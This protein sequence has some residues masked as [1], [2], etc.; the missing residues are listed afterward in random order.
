MPTKKEVTSMTRLSIELIEDLEFGGSAARLPDFPA[1]GA[2][3]TEAEA[4]ADLKEAICG[5]IETF[6]RADAIA[7]TNTTNRRKSVLAH[8][9]RPENSTGRLRL[10]LAIRIYSLNLR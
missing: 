7:R 2:G 1:Y 8:G 9:S 5:Y 10:C 6:G 4:I 3:E